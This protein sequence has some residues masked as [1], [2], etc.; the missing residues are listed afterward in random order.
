MTMHEED[1]AV[2]HKQIPL[3]V[4]SNSAKAPNYISLGAGYW[5]LCMFVLEVYILTFTQ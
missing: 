3:K 5:Q 1:N 2:F 4:H